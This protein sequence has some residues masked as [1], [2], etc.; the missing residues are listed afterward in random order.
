MVPKLP[1]E[2]R[3][4]PAENKPA[5]IVACKSVWVYVLPMTKNTDTA[6]IYCRVSTTDQADTGHS[7]ETQ[8]QRL[9]A[10]A[11]RLGYTNVVVLADEAR[12]GKKMSNR[13]SLTQALAL[14]DSGKAAA[15][16]VVDIDRLSRSVI[17]TAKIL[18]RSRRYGWRLVIVGIG[19]VD[20]NTPEGALLVSVL[21]AAAAYESAMTSQRVSRQH[22]ARRARNSVWSIDEGPKA[23]L[24]ADIRRRIL[25]MRADGQSMATIANTLNGENVPTAKGGKWYPSTIKHVIDSPATRALVAA[26]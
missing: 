26:A 7:L 9:T 17:D 3:S 10:E 2:S 12:S 18:E 14:V 23:L 21:S 1:T 15:L 22:A 5:Y 20:T 4:T 11:H 13:R 24:G 25:A 19:G 8:E 16:F 6:V